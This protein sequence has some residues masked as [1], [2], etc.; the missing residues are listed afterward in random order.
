M[1]NYLPLRAAISLIEIDGQTSPKAGRYIVAVN[2]IDILG[3]D[4]MLSA[5]DKSSPPCTGCRAVA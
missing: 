3:N 1:G 5:L 4:T 2:E